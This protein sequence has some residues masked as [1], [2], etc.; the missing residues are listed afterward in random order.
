MTDSTE[1]TNKLEGKLAARFSQ[2]RQ[3]DRAQVSAFPDNSQL[4]ERG[5]R[6]REVG[7]PTWLYTVAAAGVAALA[8]LLYPGAEDPVSVYNEI[9]A[10]NVITTD[11]LLL[12]TPGVLPE[13]TD[14][15][16]LFDTG[17]STQ[18]PQRAN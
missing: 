17:V 18:Q 11:Q 14:V 4:E 16:V 6:A 1:T 9:M 12:V 5:T 10:A 3:E 7:K 15:P 2:M 8:V 13:T